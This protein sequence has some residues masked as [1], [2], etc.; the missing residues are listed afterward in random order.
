M[1][2]GNSPFPSNLFFPKAPASQTPYARD[3]PRGLPWQLYSSLPCTSLLSPPCLH[4]QFQTSCPDI[5]GLLTLWICL[6]RL[7]YFPFVSLPSSHSKFWAF[8][9]LSPYSWNHHPPLSPS[10]VSPSSVKLSLISLIFPNPKKIL[11]KLSFDTINRCIF[12]L[13]L[14]NTG[15][16]MLDHWH[17]HTAE[18]LIPWSLLQQRIE[19]AS[20]VGHSNVGRKHSVEQN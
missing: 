17:T 18:I 20:Y 13:L 10:L 12:N 11:K 19:A 2:V 7:P 6:Y 5:Q 9:Q 1:R 16:W 8:L 14:A 3:R 15:P 4:H